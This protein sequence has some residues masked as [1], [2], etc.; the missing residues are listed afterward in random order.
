MVTKK[1]IKNRIKE[2]NAGN[3]V[4]N[5]QMI[6]FRS[7]NLFVKVKIWRN[8]KKLTIISKKDKLINSKTNHLW[9]HLKLKNKRNYHNS[10]ILK[11]KNNKIS[12]PL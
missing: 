10:I 6:E 12:L 4:E 9:G 11:K 7:I 2:Y 3:A 5:L 8:N 1:K